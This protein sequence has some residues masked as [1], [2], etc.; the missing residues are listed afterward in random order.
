MRL[1]VSEHARRRWHERF[2]RGDSEG[3]LAE[4]LREA[5][6]PDPATLHWLRTRCRVYGHV[7]VN[8]RCDAAFIL[9]QTGDGWVVVTVLV[10]SAH[11]THR[12]VQVPEARR[13]KADWQGARRPRGR[14]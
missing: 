13:H 3:A 9:R 7:L 14:G 5:V 6:P 12:F 8:V 10:L 2:V 1:T 11:R 4:A